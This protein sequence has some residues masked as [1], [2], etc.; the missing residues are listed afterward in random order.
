M[1]QRPLARH[2]VLHLLD[3]QAEYKSV[4]QCL[5]VFCK[6]HRSK[7]HRFH[8]DSACKGIL[9]RWTHQSPPHPSEALVVRWQRA[10]GSPISMLCLLYALA[11]E[12]CSSLLRV[13]ETIRFDPKMQQ[14]EDSGEEDSVAT[15]QRG[16]LV[17]VK[18]SRVRRDTAWHCVR[19]IHYLIQFVTRLLPVS[20]CVRFD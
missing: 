19:A 9:H 3:A 4:S 1:V 17:C 13:P 8:K 12:V 2:T 7:C 20:F 15:L 14:V 16:R 11:R 5:Y 6:W 18:S 10:C